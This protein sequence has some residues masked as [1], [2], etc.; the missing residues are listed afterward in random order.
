MWWNEKPGSDSGLTSPPV[1]S[2]SQIVGGT[3]GRMST[4]F[5]SR[6]CAITSSFWYSTQITVDAPA[7]V[8]QK[9]SFRST[10]TVCPCSHEPNVNG[11]VPTGASFG[12]F[13]I[14]AG[15]RSCQMCAG[16]IGIA[17]PGSNACGR[18][19]FTS[20]VCGSTAVTPV[21]SVNH[22]AYCE[23]P[24]PLIEENVNTTSSAVNGV[25]S[26]QVTPWRNAYVTVLPSAEA[27]VVS[28]RLAW[29]S[30]LAS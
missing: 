6:P 1:L 2:P 23:D 8:P 28:A 10:C 3:S 16:R 18:L 5:D 7:G 19:Y 15:L 25:P 13:W 22:W 26:C 14:W 29:I 11:P 12:N 24:P 27:V 30:R 21:M 17:S 4:S 20:T 9:S